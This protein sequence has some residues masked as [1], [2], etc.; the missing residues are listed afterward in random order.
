M[1]D[2]EPGHEPDYRFSLANERTLLA[3]VRTAF[4]LVALGIPLVGGIRGVAL[5]GWH[6]EIGLGAITL[7]VVIAPVAYRRWRRAQ[8][9]M[10]LGVCL[11]RDPLPA[12]L[13]VGVAVL[14]TATLVSGLV[15]R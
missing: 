10:R 2:V 7:S 14:F 15:T 5:P 1:S 13:T 9:A 11:P 3:W 12:V 6:R 8:E 4:G